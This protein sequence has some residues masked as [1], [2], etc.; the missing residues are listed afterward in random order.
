M[1]KW[2][3]SISLLGVLAGGYGLYSRMDP[4]PLEPI[5]DGGFSLVVIPDLQ[6]YARETP[7]LWDNVAGRGWRRLLDDPFN[8][9]LWR[10]V[11]RPFSVRDVQGM[12]DWVL[13]NKEKQNIRHLI[14]VGD[15]VGHADKEDEWRLISSEMNRLDSVV[16]F[17]ITPGNH[18]LTDGCGG[19]E[20]FDKFYPPSFFQKNKSFGGSYEGMQSSFFELSP[21]LLLVN[22]TVNAS[23]AHLAW[24]D[25][26]ITSHP[27]HKII[28]VT[29]HWLGPEKDS[30]SGGAAYQAPQPGAR[31]GIMKEKTCT[32]PFANSPEQMWLKLLSRH[33]NVFLIISGHRRWTQT[34]YVRTHGKSGNVVHSVMAD[35]S[36]EPN[37]SCFWVLRFDREM[38]KIDVRPISAS[39]RR[40]CLQTQVRPA[41]TSHRFEVSLLENR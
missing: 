41:L 10:R 21:T 6:T 37:L 40:S 15:F 4:T 34:A 12:V 25:K 23:D 14:Q 31:V 1:L 28:V 7:A 18:D 38:T 5:S 33:A 19:S 17:S 26:V 22:L 35:Y 8:A 3:L 27:T 2:I 24:A 16:P 13:L 29:H 32:T 36:E 20:N 30:G 9:D 11:L 39:D